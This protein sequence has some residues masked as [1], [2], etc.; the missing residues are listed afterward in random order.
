[1]W[2]VQTGRQQHPLLIPPGRRRRVGDV[3]GRCRAFRH[4]DGQGAA[5]L[6]PRLP[7][8]ARQHLGGHHERH[9]CVDARSARRRAPPLPRELAVVERGHVLR[10]VHRRGGQS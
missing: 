9:V 5:E 3:Q 1:M 6:P 2:C 8:R 10:E 4:A 7:L